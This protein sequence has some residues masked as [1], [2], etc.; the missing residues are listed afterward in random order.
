MGLF[1]FPLPPF[2]FPQPR[3][4]L[5]QNNQFIVISAILKPSYLQ[6]SKHFI[7]TK[8]HGL[9]HSLWWAIVVSFYS[10]PVLSQSVVTI[11]HQAVVKPL[12][13]MGT[14]GGNVKSQKIARTEN[15]PT[16]YCDGYVNTR[17]NHL[18]KLESFFEFLRLEVQS[19]ADTTI[20]VE[21]A[22]GVWCN[23]D[24]GST[25]PMI[26]GQWQAGLY[27]VWVGS[28]QAN[29]SHSYKIKISGR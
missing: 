2:P 26:E 15:T 29:T 28:Y 18:L 21:G 24:A 5:E 27:K 25:N 1:P 10:Y 13:I 11:N 9:A 22:S 20:L 8:T 23:D 16:G 19:S 4:Y 3:L 6:T 17:P 7:L 14:S 12:I